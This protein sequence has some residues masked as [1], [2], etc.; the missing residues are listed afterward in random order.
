MAPVFY[1]EVQNLVP[2]ANNQPIFTYY[3]A[4]VDAT[5][6]PPTNVVN[7]GAGVD[8]ST[9]AGA[10][11]IQTIDAIKVNL[12]TKSRQADPQSHGKQVINSIVGVAELED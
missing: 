5:Q 6:V 8:I 7:V 2:P 3:R 12:N 10:A 11:T 1:T 4:N 9:A